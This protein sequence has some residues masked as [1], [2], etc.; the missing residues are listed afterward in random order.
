MNN[1]SMPDLTK[2]LQ[3]ACLSGVILAACAA[4]S[5]C[6]PAEGSQSSA[7]LTTDDVRVE[8][9][10]GED[11]PRL[12]ALSTSAGVV[13][14]NEQAESLPQE[15]EVNG[16]AVPLTWHLKPELGS[17]DARRVIF[18]YESAVPHL[19]LRWQW[20][21]RARFGPLE[22]SI[23]VENLSGQ[24]VWAP[25]LDS[26]R[27][28]W[29][30]NSH[31]ELENLYV[32]KGADTPSAQGTHLDAVSEGYRWTGKSSTYAHPTEGEA[33]EIIP[34]EIVFSAAQPQDGW[35]AGIEFSGRT[36]IA[37]E[38]SGDSL[39]TVLG[40]ESGAGTVPHPHRAG[41]QLRNS[42]RLSG[43]LYRR[44]G[45]R[46]QSTAALGARSARQSAHVEGS[47]L[48]ADGQQQ[49]GQRNEG[50]RSAGAA[51]DRGLEGTGPGDV[52][53]GCRLVPRRGRLVS[54]SR[55]VSPRPG[56]DCRRG[57]PAGPALRHLGRLDPGRARHRA[58]RVECARSQGPRLAGDRSGDRIGSR[59]SSR[60]RP[61]IWAIPPRATGPRKR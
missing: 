8:L 58:R 41:K 61:S 26:L 9:S 7:V 50:G 39:K 43:R 2:N 23:F 53:H 46:R 31:E 10:A 20:Q 17:A 51:H 40:P 52:S 11:A 18:V 24:Q 19:R 28:A 38:R 1:E 13:W 59:R 27:L 44:T 29:R 22:H 12:V 35:Y 4:P 21:S 60:G 55:K 6:A 54:E 3:R 56:A 49:L 57:A 5:W 45:R 32:E 15:V 37:L 48:S 34:A 33:R 30:T 36:R 16:A 42:H 47:A 25:M 14:R